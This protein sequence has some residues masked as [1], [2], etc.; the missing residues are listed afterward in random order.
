MRAKSTLLALGALSLS[1][2]LFAC[3]SMLGF[4][5]FTYSTGTAGAAG[6]SQAGAAG[7]AGQAAGAGGVA[8]A[9]AAGDGGGA[10]AGAAGEAGAAGQAGAGGADDCPPGVVTGEDGREQR[11]VREPGVGCFSIDT[12]EVSRGAY[13]KFLDAQPPFNLS[14]QSTA[15]QSNLELKPDAACVAGSKTTGD[16]QQNPV[17]CV[18]WCDAA[19]YCKWAGKRLCKGS[20]ADFAEA[21]KSEWYAA[22]SNEGVNV[23]PYGSK[24]KPSACNTG[25]TT[26]PCPTDPVGSRPDCVSARGVADLSGNVA[27][28]VDE[29]ETSAGL[30]DL[31]RARGGSFKDSD[32]DAACDLSDAPKRGTR[33]ASRG[34]RCC[35]D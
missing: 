11:R 20:H 22:C 35:D 30:E 25:C 14:L 10:G 19:A 12:Q 26:S 3:E 9:G 5:E 33:D 32:G 1:A 28:W 29:C 13:Q 24:S 8:T 31:C 15:C 21:G 18:D 27:E 23:Y 17:V 6:A 34:F 16:L 2:S 4:D 7:A